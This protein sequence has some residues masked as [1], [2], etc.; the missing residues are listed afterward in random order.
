M[1]TYKNINQL[2]KAH[3][4]ENFRQFARALYK[5]TACGPWTRLLLTE[6][7]TYYYEDKG[8]DDPSLLIDENIL[9]IDIGSIVE[10]SDVEVGPIA[11]HFPFTSMQLDEAVKEINDEADF[12][13][14]RDNESSYRITAPDGK[15]W[16]ADV[17][18]SVSYDTPPTVDAS[19]VFEDFI[20]KLDEE[21]EEDS[22]TLFK[23][24]TIYRIDKSMLT[25]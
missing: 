5:N 1:K 12:Y 17:G 4:C 18:F 9:G 16:F 22:T 10:G 15:E 19:D 6:G 3:G 13:W 8:M 2:V 11:L 21:V 14:K 20:R 25:Y 24:Y 7:R 23:G